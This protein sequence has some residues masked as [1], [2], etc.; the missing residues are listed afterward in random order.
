M[1]TLSPLPTH[2][3]LPSCKHTDDILGSSSQRSDNITAA[4][5]SSLI[6]NS[7]KNLLDMHDSCSMMLNQANHISMD[8]SCQEMHH[9]GLAEER[10]GMAVVQKYAS[11][12]T[13]VSHTQT[14]GSNM[15][16]TS[17]LV[18]TGGLCV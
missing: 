6:R 10:N 13:V 14:A 17:A 9:E 3:G 8:L 12:S 7:G 2:I 15:S 4:L 16:A 11:D 18:S 1:Q 5:S